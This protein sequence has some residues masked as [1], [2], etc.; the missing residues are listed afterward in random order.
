MIYPV[1]YH[2]NSLVEFVYDLLSFYLVS[3]VTKV[4][5]RQS[6]EPAQLE[7]NTRPV[8]PSKR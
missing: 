8:F 7:S 3:T 5:V 1:L 4:A 6:C 2:I